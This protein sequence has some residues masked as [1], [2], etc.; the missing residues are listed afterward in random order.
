MLP[1]TLIGFPCILLILGGINIEDFKNMY[2][3]MFA[4][5]PSMNMFSYV[6]RIEILLPEKWNFD[7]MAQIL[8]ET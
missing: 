7:I 3:N 5:F 4:V 2:I 6:F 8:I 1:L